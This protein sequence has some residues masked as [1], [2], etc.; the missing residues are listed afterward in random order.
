M[1]VVS[2]SSTSITLRM[3]AS[4]AFTV[5]SGT[6]D[7][8]PAT[9]KPVDIGSWITVKQPTVTLRPQQAVVMPFTLTVPANATPGDHTGG[10]VASLI[11]DEERTGVDLDRRLGSRI[12]LRA[13]MSG[14][15]HARRSTSPV[16]GASWA[17]PPRWPTCLS[18][19][20]EVRSPG[21]PPCMGSGQPLI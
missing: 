8:L 13:A 5:P 2:R 17:T 15:A 16:H 3:Y 1:T 14:Y 12:Y 11:S 21:P 6:M 4:D 10:V 19:C 18:F 7:L 9:G 20:L